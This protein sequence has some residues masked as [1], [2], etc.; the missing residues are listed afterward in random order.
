[1]A[2][3]E[4]RQE[5]VQFVSRNGEPFDV[6]IESQPDE[7]AITLDRKKN[8]AEMIIAITLKKPGVWQGAIKVKAQTP[9]GKHVMEIGCVGYGRR[10]E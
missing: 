10:A 8:P 4:S 5:T 9:S 6:Q 7:C 1:M 3:G 2:V